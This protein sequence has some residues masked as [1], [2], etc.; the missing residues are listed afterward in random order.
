MDSS[1]R[2][3]ASRRIFTRALSLA[4]IQYHQLSIVSFHGSRHAC[5]Q[6]SLSQGSPSYWDVC[7]NTGKMNSGMIGT[8]LGK[9]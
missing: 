1:L 2:E 4:M 7:A 3:L 5:L 9:G 6:S 8:N